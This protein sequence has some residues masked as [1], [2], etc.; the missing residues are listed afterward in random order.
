MKKEEKKIIQDI[1]DLYKRETAKE[2]YEINFIEGEPDILDDK[3]CGNPYIPIGEEY[4][5]DKKGNNLLLLLQVN[6]KNINLDN[7]PKKG[8]LEIF[9]SPNM[10]SNLEYVVKLYEEGKEYIKDLPKIDKSKYLCKVNNKIKLTKTEDYMSNMDYRYPETIIKVLNKMTKE[11]YKNV[12]EAEKKLEINIFNFEKKIPK[13]DISLG[14]YPD[15]TQDDP[16]P[17]S[18]GKEECLFK[19]DSNARKDIRIGDSGILYC[20]IS[21]KDLKDGNFDNVYLSWDCL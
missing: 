10:I 11:N 19:L 5:K 12:E 14:G 7:F 18:D 8:I 6:L 4:P 2:C 9:T 13:I 17:F 3:I 21:K 15:F 20:F 16:R 1:L